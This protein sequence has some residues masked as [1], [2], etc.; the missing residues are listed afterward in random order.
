MVAFLADVELSCSLSSLVERYPLREKYEYSVTSVFNLARGG[1]N[2]MKKKMVAVAY[3]NLTQSIKQ[4]PTR[5]RD[6]RRG[7]DQVS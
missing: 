4:R 7:M 2:I 1:Y 6:E 3:K 5:N